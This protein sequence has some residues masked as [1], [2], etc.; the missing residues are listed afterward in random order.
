MKKVVSLVLAALL[1]LGIASAFAEAAYQPGE[2]T[3]SQPGFGG[4][5]T[6]A[7][8]T[9]ETKILS[10]T[11]TGEAETPQIGGRAIEKLPELLLAA[12]GG[13]VDAI[14]GAT[15]TSSAVLAAYD[16]AVLQ[17]KGEEAAAAAMVPGTYT[18]VNKGFGGLVVAT[19]ELS[20]DA[21]LSV[22]LENTQDENPNIDPDDPMK[23][24]PIA[25]TFETPQFFRGVEERLPERI[26]EYQS[27]AVDAITGATASSLAVLEGVKDCIRQ[28]GGNVAAFSKPI[29]KKEATEEYDCDIAVIGGGT[30]GSIAS[31]RAADLGAKV[32]LI[33]KSARVGGCGSLSSGP[34]A[35]NTKMSLEA[36]NVSN[37]E[38]LMKEWMHITHW[39]SRGYMM[40]RFLEESGKTIDWMNDHGFQMRVGRGNVDPFTGKDYGV[41]SSGYMMDSKPTLD[42]NNMY[43]A[44]VEQ[45]LE[46]GGSILYETRA[47]KLITDDTGA[48]IGVEAVKDDGTKVKVNCKAVIIGTG[49]YAA[50]EEMMMKYIGHKHRLFGLY[51]NVGDGINMMLDV[52]AATCNLDAV[53]TH[54]VD[55]WG[56]PTGFDK[57]EANMPFGLL[58][59]Y[60][61]MRFN[62]R[63]E[64]FMPENAMTIDLAAAGNYLSGQGECFYTLVSQE[65]LEK[66]KEGGLAAL[67]QDVRAHVVEYVANPVRP[68]LKM[69]NINTILDACVEQGLA[70]KGDTIAELAESMGIYA[71]QLERS[72]AMYD[73]MCE[74]GEDTLFYKDAKY[75]SKIGEGPYYAI[76][77]VAVIYGTLG[78]V[79]INE[80]IQVLREDHTPIPGLYAIGLDSTGVLYDGVAYNAIGGTALGWAMTSGRL[81]AECAFENL[82]P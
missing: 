14:A 63:G 49:G 70:Y 13:P 28:A 21:I 4:E 6:V 22:K 3:A 39:Y 82:N 12:Q 57:V 23:S 55:V 8:K 41:I 44:C 76:T 26:V 61:L 40:H 33:E 60:V 30:S 42:V 46:K 73:E 9:D 17:A 59:S 45:V 69:P 58:S 25:M 47:T 19:V 32:V 43:V 29:P 48:V 1:I 65:Q 80:K 74:K 75:M 37:Q 67:G 54:V 81:A 77:G 38:E 24:Y 2:Y 7:I 53:S 11:V 20:E 15:A 27:V 34:M 72:V 51:Q 18:S 64:R 71:P 50:N 68:E 66:I 10:V 35:L 79:D 31:G 52:G 62:D 5:V 36:G 56:E 78:G 16:A